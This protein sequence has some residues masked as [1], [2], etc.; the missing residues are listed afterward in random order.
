MTMQATIYHGLVVRAEKGFL[1]R[2]TG[3]V[4]CGVTGMFFF[5][6]TTIKNKWVYIKLRLYPCVC[7]VT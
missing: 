4:L 7:F 5:K 6:D 2:L 3:R 1:K